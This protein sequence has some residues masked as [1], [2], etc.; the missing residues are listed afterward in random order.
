MLTFLQTPSGHL[1]YG[2][3][4]LTTASEEQFHYTGRVAKASVSEVTPSSVVFNTP[5]DS[6]SQVAHPCYLFVCCMAYLRLN[7]AEVTTN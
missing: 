3:A 7:A 6:V 5:S 1:A 4:L 2:A